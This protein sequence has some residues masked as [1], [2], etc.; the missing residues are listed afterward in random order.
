MKNNGTS[1]TYQLVSSAANSGYQF[2]CLVKNA[3]GSVY[4]NTVTL[5][6]KPGISSQPTNKTVSAGETAVFKVTASGAA[7][8]QW[9]YRKSAS[10]SWVSVKNNGTASTYNLTTIAS[11]NGY[12]FRC[13][14]KNSVG[15]VYSSVV[16][17]TVK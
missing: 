10:D 15:S 8:Y 17:L 3:A 13:L 1:A 6:V 7:S 12:Q 9:Y 2:R 14:V 16:T 5:K 4:T 11:H